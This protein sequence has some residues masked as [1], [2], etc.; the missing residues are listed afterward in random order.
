MEINEFEL[1][2]TDPTVIEN[3]GKY[4]NINNIILEEEPMAIQWM[5]E[6]NVY[7]TSEFGEAVFKLHLYY[8]KD[9]YIMDFMPSTD[10]DALYNP[11]IRYLTFWAQESGWNAPQP[12]PDLVRENTAFW[13]HFW[14]TGL[15]N[16]DFLV[17]KFGPRT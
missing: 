14:E 8:N 2:F 12:F 13:K 4:E 3:D 11:D 7:V 9:V 15:I 5:V 17:Q 6:T 1:E 16:S 10:K